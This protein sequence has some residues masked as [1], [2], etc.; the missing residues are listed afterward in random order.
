MGRERAE[1]PEAAGAQ[2]G[3]R[4]EWDESVRNF[5]KLHAVGFC[6]FEVAAEE[7]E[8]AAC[9][10]VAQTTLEMLKRCLLAKF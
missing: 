2:V 9:T 5:Q 4:K 8:A 10:V 6:G 3:L 1:P 7:I